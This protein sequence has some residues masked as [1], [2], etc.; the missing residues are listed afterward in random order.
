MA[1]L[2]RPAAGDF[3]SL[4]REMDT[5]LQ[6][7]APTDAA[8]AAWSP[9]ADIVELEDEYHVTLDLPGIDPGSLDVTL[10]DGVLT[11]SGERSV[12]DEVREGRFHRVE[13]SYGRFARSFRLGPHVDASTVEA[14]L[15]DG[16][17]TVTVRKA[18]TA[19][20]RRIEV[21]SQNR[22][23]GGTATRADGDASID[24]MADAEAATSE[25]ADAAA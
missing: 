16:V 15:E 17:L 18:E 4:R 13:R 12:R 25:T 19:K 3:T 2:M 14:G 21:R 6:A 23:A 9:R 7:L 5:L 10:D 8:S 1:S 24:R 20:P 11:I 22:V